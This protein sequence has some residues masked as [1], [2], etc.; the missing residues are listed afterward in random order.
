[1]STIIVTMPT[2]HAPRVNNMC[3]QHVT[4]NILFIHKVMLLLA[5]KKSRSLELANDTKTGEQSIF[6]KI[7]TNHEFRMP[8]KE[9]PCN[10]TNWTRKRGM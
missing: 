6:G 10:A 3:V 7:H 5:W 9:D 1:M 4:Y 2:A 8:Y